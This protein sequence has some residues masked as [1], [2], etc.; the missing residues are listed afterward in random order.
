M[1]MV[2]HFEYC[3]FYYILLNQI[4]CLNKIY[5]FYSCL[6]NILVIIYITLVKFVDVDI[7]VLKDAMN[8]GDVKNIFL[9]RFVVNPLA[10]HLKHTKFM[11]V[12]FILSNFILDN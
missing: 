2:N 4:F 3:I 7:D 12:I 11:L 1:F 8:I 6:E 5:F 9:V 10:L